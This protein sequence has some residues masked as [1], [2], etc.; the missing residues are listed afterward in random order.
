MRSQKCSVLHELQIILELLR[1]NS[2]VSDDSW[3]YDTK[4]IYESKEHVKIIVY[5]EAMISKQSIRNMQSIRIAT[6]QSM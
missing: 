6:R 4:E 3:P 5:E 1:Q 2:P